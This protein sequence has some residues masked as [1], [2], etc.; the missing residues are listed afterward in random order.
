M[1]PMD[2]NEQI[3]QLPFLQLLHN[4]ANAK[5]LEPEFAE[6]LHENLW[7]LYESPEMKVDNG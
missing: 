2:N 3:I 6:V 5:P 1:Q 7:E 4:I